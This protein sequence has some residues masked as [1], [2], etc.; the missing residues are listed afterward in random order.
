M[1]WLTLYARSRRLPSSLAVLAV[2]AALA[3]LGD[4]GLGGPRAAALLLAAGAM[5]LSAGLGGQDLDLDRAAALRWPP[6]RAAH[7]LLCA[8]LAAAVLPP[9]PLALTVRDSAGLTGLA[10]LGAVCWGHRYAWLPPFGWLGLAFVLPPG[11]G[12]VA[13]ILG[14]PLLPPGA[15]PAAWTALALAAAGTAAYA[16]AGPRR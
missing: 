10:A 14:W 12:P 13:Q 8:V 16:L 4:G 7:V 2:L 5:A 9:G 1:R 11:P 3:R 6:R 15:A